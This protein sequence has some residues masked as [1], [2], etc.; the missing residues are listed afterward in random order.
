[1]VPTS[2]ALS[3]RPDPGTDISGTTSLLGMSDHCLE[4]TVEMVVEGPFD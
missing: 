3:V 4:L 1:M 2:P